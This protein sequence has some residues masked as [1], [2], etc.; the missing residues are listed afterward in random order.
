VGR[1]GSRLLYLFSFLGAKS[2]DPTKVRLAQCSLW[3]N[4]KSPW[5][6]A[7]GGGMDETVKGLAYCFPN[8]NY[9]NVYWIPSPWDTYSPPNFTNSSRSAPSPQ[10]LYA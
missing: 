4:K 7:R 6:L 8:D 9:L 1:K 10:Q 3:N 2:G 5:Q